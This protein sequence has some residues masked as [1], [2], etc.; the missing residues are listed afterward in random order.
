MVLSKEARQF[1][2]DVATLGMVHRVKPL[3]GPVSL[4]ARV[5]R[6]AKRG[7]LMNREKILSDAL[8]GVAYHNDKQIVE[9]HFHQADDK[10]N[11]RVE[12]E[13]VSVEPRLF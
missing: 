7:D 10:Q 3:D 5:Y 12:V 8:E 13:I 4:T 11:P 9:C 2:K 1:K 6:P